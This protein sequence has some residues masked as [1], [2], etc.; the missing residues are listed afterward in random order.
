MKHLAKKSLAIS[1]LALFFLVLPSNVDAS[2][3]HYKL[4]NL[5]GESARCEVDAI[6]MPNQ[7]YQM[8]IGCR[9]I[10]YP[11]GESIF[12]YA[13]WGN[14]EAGGNPV[15]LDTLGVGKITVETRT[16]FSS[17]FVTRETTNKPRNPVG[18]IVMQ[19]SLERS[20]FLDNPNAVQLPASEL[21]E[22]EVSPTPTIVQGRSVN[23]AQIGGVV[24][25]FLL[26]GII[27]M[28]FYITR[29]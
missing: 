23:I 24:G 22:P 28:I 21:G 19:G 13:L 7:E 5:V 8:L 6:L 26:F 9:D 11:G 2:E 17:M 4:K 3:R 14:P 20:D 29:K 25:F 12:S 15:Y 27:L 16:A 1:F 10:V 18:T